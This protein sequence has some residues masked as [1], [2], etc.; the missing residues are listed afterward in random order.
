MLYVHTYTV[1]VTYAIIMYNIKRV[2]LYSH[3]GGAAASII[4]RVY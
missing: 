3:E 4:S 1:F 2:G